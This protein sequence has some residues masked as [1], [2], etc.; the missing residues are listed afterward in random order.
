MAKRI[1]YNGYRLDIS[2]PDNR[3]WFLWFSKGNVDLDKS[4][5]FV[6]SFSKFQLA[7]GKPENLNNIRE[8]FNIINDQYCEEYLGDILQDFT[9]NEIKQI[10]S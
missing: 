6:K 7:Y 9:D 5:D 1:T 3:K 8:I 2:T 4:L 10:Y